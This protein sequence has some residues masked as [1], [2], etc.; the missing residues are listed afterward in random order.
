VSGT[1]PSPALAPPPGNPRLPLFDGIRAVAIVLVLACHSA[2]LARATQHASWGWL[3]LSMTITVDLFFGVSGFLLYRPYASAHAGLR[4]APTARKY[5]RRRAL[6][7][8]PGYWLALT[9]LAIWPGIQGPF[10]DRWWVYYGF[11][12]VYSSGTAGRGDPVAWSLATEVAFYLALPFLAALGAR[13]VRARGGRRW[14]LSELAMIAP[15]GIAALVVMGLC[16]RLIVPAWLNTTLGCMSL[17]FA[18]G[19]GLAVASVELERGG[20]RRWADF[21]AE[22][23]WIVWLGAAVVFFATARWLDI[24]RFL[25]GHP[26]ARAPSIAMITG[27]QVGFAV[28]VALA[29]LPAAVGGRGVVARLLASRPFEFVGTISYGMFLWHLPLMCWLASFHDTPDPIPGIHGGLA[30]QRHLPG[31]DTLV[32]FVAAL[33]ISLPVAALSYRFV[34]L[35]FLRLKEHRPSRGRHSAFVPLIRRRLSWASTSARR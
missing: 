6:R 3:A 20:P 5:F 2:T 16:S 11:G 23:T 14:W 7:I 21:V 27:H 12:Q 33:V 18:V 35:P 25:E 22:R 34:E 15:F 9:L 26:D 29:L 4:P 1:A 32:L 10:S 28:A 13:L 31:P 17:W 19:M 8:L 30:I 24:T